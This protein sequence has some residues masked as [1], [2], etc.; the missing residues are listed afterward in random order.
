MASKEIKQVIDD[1]INRYSQELRSMSLDVSH[2]SP[3]RIHNLPGNNIM[4]CRF[5]ITLKEEIKNTEHLVY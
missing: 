1:T 4:R 2:K 5:M 3:F